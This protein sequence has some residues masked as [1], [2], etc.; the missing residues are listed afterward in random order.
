[1]L[2]LVTQRP[3]ITVA[4]LAAELAV[5]ATGLYGVVRRLQG[6]GQLSKDGTQLR[7]TDAAAPAGADT[8]DLAPEPSAGAAATPPAN[9][10]SSAPAAADVA[11]ETAAAGDSN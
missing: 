8:P 2:R 1:M 7:L 10:E 5:D 3:G 4:E 6:K 11:E 9:G